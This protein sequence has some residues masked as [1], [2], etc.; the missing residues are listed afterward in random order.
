[1]DETMY[2]YTFLYC[3]FMPEESSWVEK[4]GPN[5]RMLFK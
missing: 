2:L 1:M 4:R 5:C 3:Y